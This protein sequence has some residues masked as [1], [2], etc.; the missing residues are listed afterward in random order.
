MVQ[1][2]HKNIKVVYKRQALCYEKQEETKMK[3]IVSFAM[4]ALLSVTALTGCGGSVDADNKL[5]MATNAEFPPYEY[6]EGGNVVGLDVDMAK[7]VAEKLGMELEINNINFDAIIPAIQSG[8]A[9]IGVAGMTV[10]ED[11]KLS[12]DFTD[13]YTTATQVIIV[14]EENPA[15]TSATDLSGKKIGVQLGTTGDIYAT[16]E[17][18]SVERF[19]KGADAIMALSQRKIDCVMI[20]E[21]P[22]KK[23]VESNE[24]LVIL[25]E[26][27]AVEEYAIALKKGNTELQ[28]KING[29]LKELKADGTLDSIVAKYIN[30]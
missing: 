26:E 8:K 12:V 7:A 23:F 15:V 20:D 28:E 6:M 18:D 21:E 29:A 9:D 27:F 22:A 24:G 10:T 30:E 5:T 11:R 19:N 2:L 4:A 16:D 1:Y 14:N 13:S 17:S 3:K 25:D